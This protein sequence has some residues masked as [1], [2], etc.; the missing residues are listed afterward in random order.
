MTIHAIQTGS[1]RIKRSQVR[2]RGHGL[3][4]RLAVFA[5]PQ[6]TDWLPTYAWMI[7]HPEGIIVV[8]TGQECTC[9]TAPDRCTHILQSGCVV[10][11]P[12]D[13]V[14]LLS[15]NRRRSDA[16]ARPSS[17]WGFIGSKSLRVRRTKA[18]VPRIPVVALDFTS[19]NLSNP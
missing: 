16:F 9:S 3:R 12:C 8:D 18:N 11:I 5:D 7:D 19:S 2:G 10:M 13:H 14:E 6:W 4:R 1:V 15:S 17:A